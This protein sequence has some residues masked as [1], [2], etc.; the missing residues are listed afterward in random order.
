MRQNSLRK[1]RDDKLLPKRIKVKNF[2]AIP[3]ADI[4]LSGISLASIVGANGFGK[5]TL[6]TW[7]PLFALFGKTKNGC[8]IDD[9]VKTGEQDML[10]Q[11]DF[12]H[13]GSEYQ[14]IRTRSLKGKGKSALELQK[15]VN[16][17]Y[18]S[19]SGATIDETEAK[20]RALL[21][22]DA[23]TFISSSMILQGDSSNFPR[24][25]PGKR[26][27]ILTKILGLDIYEKL[28]TAAREREKA[29]T[30]K[31]ETSKNK[32]AELEDKLRV[33][34]E[35]EQQ[36]LD[37]SDSITLNACDIREKETAL[38]DAQGLV[39][40]LEEKEQRASTA[41][42]QM[43][44]ISADI[45]SMEQEIADHDLK[46]QDA[47]R[48]L[49]DES[50]INIKVAELEKIKAQIPVLQAK[51]DRIAVLKADENRIS[52]EHQDL[53]KE[54][55]DAGRRIYTLT[56]ELSTRDELKQANDDYQQG[57][58][59][60]AELD[61]S[62]DEWQS[63]Q[64]DITRSEKQLEQS[65]SHIKQLKTALQN[66]ETKANL[67]DTANCP[68]SGEIN[69]VFLKDATEAKKQIPIIE[70]NQ[71]EADKE[72]TVILDI[73]KGLTDR[74]EA[75]NYDKAHHADLKKRTESLRQKAEAYSQLAGKEE[76][77][78]NLEG[79]RDSII[80]RL[81]LLQNSLDTIQQEIKQLQAETENLP[82]LKASIPSLE[83]YVTMRD[84]LPEAR[85]T[86]KL[87]QDAITK[88]QADIEA[89]N[90]QYRELLAQYA[91]L[92]AQFVGQLPEARQ[93]IDDIS[94]ELKELASTQNALYAKQGTIKAKLEALTKDAEEKDR[95]SAELAPKV[96]ELTRWQTLV[97]AFG[98]NGVQALILENAIPELERIS[99]DILSQM[100]NG[101]HSLRFETQRDLKSKDGVAET[102]DIIVSDWAGSRPYETYSGGEQLRIDLAIRFALAELLSNRAGSKIEFIVGDELLSSQDP[103]HRELVIDAIKA[104]SD[105]FKMVLIISHIPE[106]QE[107][108]DQKIRIGEGGKVEVEF[109]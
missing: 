11:F 34:P 99:N 45:K 102:L 28:Q 7:A 49:M 46:I 88:L 2:G 30:I 103:E 65:D 68:V 26:K 40:N 59:E 3:E 13:Q 60:L 53:L 105:R 36:M 109:N 61:K 42:T 66:H 108:F 84:K 55:N 94:R 10:V 16:G 107:A 24:K 52:K 100:S 86:I 97:K 5:S 95:L 38:F 73:I 76:L 83:K 75:L 77:L 56:N 47:K 37:I 93:N 23:D 89:K 4:E 82:I 80:N 44:T 48:T 63:Y 12:E 101:A 9:L 21:N 78:K 22:L 19:L 6:F 72:R 87:S 29:L 57:L 81:N 104:V 27:A 50:E 85:T 31:L 18:E 106:V 90:K 64:D 74:Q 39:K 92:S 91:E 70:N 62:A 51:E 17:R 71:A 67:L 58:S 98:K 14:V 35:T 33:L 25:A 1:L 20:I 32:L 43:D 69:C 15:L 96:K 8:G 41:K 54:K 79:Q